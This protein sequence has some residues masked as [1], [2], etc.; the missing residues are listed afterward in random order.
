MSPYIDVPIETLIKRLYFQ[1]SQNVILYIL[2]IL[3]PHR[4][5]NNYDRLK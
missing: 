3:I 4:D 2:S 5:G 1:E